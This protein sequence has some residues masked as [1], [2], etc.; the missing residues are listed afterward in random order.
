MCI[1]YIYYS[2]L[3]QDIDILYNI[4]KN[5]NTLLVLSFSLATA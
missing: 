2:E 1:M 4:C 3:W 5:D